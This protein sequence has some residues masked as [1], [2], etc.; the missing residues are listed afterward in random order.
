MRR[1]M[2][3]VRG[4]EH[5]AYKEQLRELGWFGLEMRMFRADLITL[6]NSLKGS[7]DELVFCLFSQVKTIG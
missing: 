3:L 1:G 7:C 2:K 4:L 6:Y 5:K